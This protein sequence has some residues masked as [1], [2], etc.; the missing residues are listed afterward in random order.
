MNPSLIKSTTFYLVRTRLHLKHSLLTS[1]GDAPGVD[2]GKSNRSNYLWIS[3]LELLH[4]LIF[5]YESG[6]MQPREYIRKIVILMDVGL[7]AHS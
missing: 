5:I 6:L 4:C 2:G 3:S 1:E 7:A